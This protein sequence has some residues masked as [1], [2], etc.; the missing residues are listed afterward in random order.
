MTQ[1]RSGLDWRI[2]FWVSLLVALVFLVH[3][4]SAV[5]LPFV[6]GMVL[7][8]LLNPVANRLERAGLNRLGAALLILVVFILAVGLTLILVAPLLGRQL[9]AFVTSLPDNLNRL[10]SLITNEAAAFANTY[11]SSMIAK[12]G[13]D[14]L[15]LGAIDWK[16]LGLSSQASPGALP[17]SIGT[18]AGQGAQT[19]G[20]LLSSLWS[21]G[22]TLLSI[23]SL[24]VITPVVA[25]YFV[26]DWARL[27]ATLDNLVPLNQRDEVHELLAEIDHALG[28]FL[29]GQSLVCLFLGLW[30]GIGLS[31][32]G[33]NY[34]FLIGITA[35]LLSFIPYLG[36][37]TALLVGTSMALVQGW[38]HWSL[39]FFA[40]GVVG[41]GQMLEANVLAPKLVGE[42]V[43]LHPVWLMFALLAFG[44]LFGF[45]GLLIAVP[46]AAALGVLMRFAVRRYRASPLYL[47]EEA[48]VALPAPVEP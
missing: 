2:V 25:F 44:S 22:S 11:G 12:F 30:Y 8:Y 6:A 4:L 39:F 13:L 45:T 34:G 42:S 38:P 31:L 20:A 36:S 19:L 9:A 5:M 37:L 1:S 23:G 3:L 43:G 35:G 18:L 41:I 26:L 33:L 15:G 7:G 46:V 21:G 24:L 29:R 32:I 10:E 16:N 17:K 40:L 48:P 47:G 27:V 28:G 14:K